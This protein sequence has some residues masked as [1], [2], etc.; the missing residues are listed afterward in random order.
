[1]PR[2]R[3]ATSNPA[4]IEFP[5]CPHCGGQ[6]MLTRIEPDAPGH[7]RRTFECKDCGHSESKTVA[8]RELYEHEMQIVKGQPHPLHH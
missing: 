6:M 1:M 3:K 8:F 4:A 7:D 2:F 5:R